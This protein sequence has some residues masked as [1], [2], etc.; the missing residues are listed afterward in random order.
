VSSHDPCGGCWSTL[1]E[2]FVLP[3]GQ[4]SVDIALPIKGLLHLTEHEVP[5]HG[6]GH[7]LVSKAH[8]WWWS[9]MHICGGEQPVSSKNV[10]QS[11]RT[12]HVAFAIPD[13]DSSHCHRPPDFRYPSGKTAGSEHFGSQAGRSHLGTSI[14]PKSPTGQRAGRELPVYGGLQWTLHNS[15]DC[16]FAHSDTSYIQYSSEGKSIGSQLSPQRAAGGKP[17]SIRTIHCCE[18]T[19]GLVKTQATIMNSHS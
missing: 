14:S 18:T 8:L 11:S 1:R 9:S 17:R 16:K 4:L 10:L 15:P 12:R 2:A 5:G 6:S 3:V 13:Q 7:P 19:W